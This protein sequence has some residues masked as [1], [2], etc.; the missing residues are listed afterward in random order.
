MSEP[1]K[2]PPIRFELSA[3]EN[4]HCS[5]MRNRLFFFKIDALF[6]HLNQILSFTFLKNHRINSSKLSLCI[7]LCQESKWCRLDENDDG[8]NDG[9]LLIVLLQMFWPTDHRKTV[10]VF[11]MIQQHSNLL[12][13][14]QRLYF[15]NA[16]K[17]C[18]L[19]MKF[20]DLN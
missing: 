20:E 2:I 13:K 11:K 18:H 16:L 6:L 12:W 10:S 14:I 8:T 4:C 7:C 9:V 17:L 5:L 15:F 19:K 3:L 1:D